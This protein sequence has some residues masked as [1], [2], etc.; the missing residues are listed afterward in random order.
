MGGAAIG[1]VLYRASDLIIDDR[2]SGGERF[3][4][5]LAAFVVNPMRGLT[6]IFSV[7]PGKAQYSD[8][9]SEFPNQCRAIVRRTIAYIVG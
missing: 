7:M 6:R 9:I 2:A 4:R 8:A 1:E 3:G 5:E